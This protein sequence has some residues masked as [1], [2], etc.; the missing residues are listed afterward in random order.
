MLSHHPSGLAVVAAP[1]R[2]AEMRS[3]DPDV[4]TRLL[5]LVSS[6]FDYVVFDMPRTWFSWTDSVLL[7]SN[8]LFI[9][10]EMTVPGLR[11]AKQLVE[12]VRE[13][14]GEGPLP[15]VIINRFVQKLFSSGL[16]KNDI[17]QVLGESF[18][19]CIPNNYGLVR[20]AIDRGI[21][22]D[23]VKPGNQITQQ[24]RRLIL[25]QPA[26]KPVAAPGAGVAGKLKLSWSKS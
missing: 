24:L 13:R 1:N 3:F 26:A 5:D 25:P 14:L 17:E 23:E 18:A 2:P 21:P 22:L 8:K 6:H 12:A 7:G 16:R 20:E 15:Q 10:S 11:H 19:A 4:V 9:V